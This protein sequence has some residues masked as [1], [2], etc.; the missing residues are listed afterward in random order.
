[1]RKKPILLIITIAYLLCLTLFHWGGKIDLGI[2]FFLA[3]GVL[4]IYFLD[5]ADLL[6]KISPFRPSLQGEPS[7]FRNVVFQS[8]LAI[9]SLFVLTSSGSVFGTGLVLTMFLRIL[10][11][12]REELGQNGNLQNWFAVIK[13]EILPSTQKIY[14]AV[15]V[16]IFIFLSFLFV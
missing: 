8:A 5:L 12:Q 1:M 14:F 11:D 2:L 15:M 6:F 7:P 16:G 9:L 3:G 4:G 10:L 13:T